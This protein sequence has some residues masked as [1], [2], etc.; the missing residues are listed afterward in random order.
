VEHDLDLVASVAEKIFVL[1]SGRLVFEGDPAGFRNSEVV[2][3]L[4]IGS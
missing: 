3:S 2:T 4:L 1:S